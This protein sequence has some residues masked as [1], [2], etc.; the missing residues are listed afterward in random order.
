MTPK[1]IAERVQIEADARFGETIERLLYL[2]ESQHVCSCSTV[3]YYDPINF[4]LR[5]KRVI[6]NNCRRT[7]DNEWREIANFSNTVRKCYCDEMP[8]SARLC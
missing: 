1:Q 5:R 3:S 6:C 4:E 7:E 8:Q 2:L